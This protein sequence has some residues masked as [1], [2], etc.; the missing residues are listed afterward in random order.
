MIQLTGPWMIWV[1]VGVGKQD[2]AQAFLRFGSI[3][4]IQTIWGGIRHVVLS[5]TPDCEVG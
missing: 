5:V 1:G 4:D 2:G 3:A